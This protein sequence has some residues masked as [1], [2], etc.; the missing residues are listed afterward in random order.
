M[1][2]LW[3]YSTT[4]C[5]KKG[6]NNDHLTHQTWS[7]VSGRRSS[8]HHPRLFALGLS[9]NETRDQ[10]L[11]SQIIYPRLAESLAHWQFTV[12]SHFLTSVLTAN[13]QKQDV[14]PSGPSP[15]N[16]CPGSTRQLA[17]IVPIPSTLLY[18]TR[19]GAIILATSLKP[20]SRSS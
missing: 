6:K 7:S 19:L 2:S 16:S 10:S 13:G 17:Q 4:E 12:K 15:K 18:T 8:Y 11:A 20:V 3:N 1:L 5:A 9:V 14:I